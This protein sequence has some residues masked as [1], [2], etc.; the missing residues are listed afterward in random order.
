MPNDKSPIRVLLVEDS[1]VALIVLK[2]ILS[3]TGEIEVV[4]TARS[5][6]EGLKLIPQ[7]RPQV[8][9][10]DLHMPHMDGLEFTQEV[11]ATYPRPILVISASVQAEDTQNVFRLLQAGAVD[12]FPKPRHGLSGENYESLKRELVTKIKVL[13]GVAVF[14]L[15]RRAAGTTPTRATKPQP[16]PT[17]TAT[18]TPATPIR[19]P[20][21][22][23]IPLSGVPSPRIVAVGASTGGPQALHGILTHLPKNF[24]VPIVCVQH[25]SQ[26][27]LQGLVNWLAIECKLAV[28]VAVPGEFPQAGVVYFPPEQQHLEFNSRCQFVCSNAPPWKGHRPS[29]TVMFQSI[30]QRYGRNSLAVLLTGMGTDGADGMASIHRAGG[31][32]IAQDEASSVV[33]GMPKA[34][35]AL[36][37]AQ[38]VLP[39]REIASFLLAKVSN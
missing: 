1:P 11:M 9:C 26:G 14:T 34:A 37:A 13:S 10:T 27:F 31:I 5:G 20:S 17:P 4:G 3:S 12:V 32:T 7:V 6:V 23:F 22:P 38:H 33:F 16:A 25:I 15:R 39:V 24:P 2:R 28:R 29:A 35:I 30:A 19:T 36:N 21:R 18:P 8:I